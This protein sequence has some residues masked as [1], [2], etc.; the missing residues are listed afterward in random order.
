M[1]LSFSPAISGFIS[2]RAG[3]VRDI[4]NK[5]EYLEGTGVNRT[6]VCEA[7]NI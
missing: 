2:S 6:V 4:I 3:D 1:L 7:S 5:K